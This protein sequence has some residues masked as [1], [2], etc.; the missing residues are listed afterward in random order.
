MSKVLN[1]KDAWQNKQK[2]KGYLYSNGY[3]EIAVTKD[4]KKE[5]IKIPIKAITETKW[6][7]KWLKENPAPE[8]PQIDGVADSTTGRVLTAE[9]VQKYRKNNKPT[10][11]VKISDT[12]DKKYVEKY[13]KWTYNYTLIQMIEV[14]DMKEEFNYED[15]DKFE[16]WLTDTEHGIGMTVNQITQIGNDIKNLDTK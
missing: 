10:E 14:F 1:M 4:G 6:L 5:L 15:L 3:S 7:K 9:E 11:R 2:Y 8:A 13:N 12:T 16:E